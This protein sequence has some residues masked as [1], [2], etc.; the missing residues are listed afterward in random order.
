MFI[1]LSRVIIKFLE[2]LDYKCDNFTKTLSL[3]SANE[4]I[5]SHLHAI[6]KQLANNNMKFTHLVTYHQI[7]S[8]ILANSIKAEL[9]DV[10]NIFWHSKIQ[11]ISTSRCCFKKSKNEIYFARLL[12]RNCRWMFYQGKIL[13]RTLLLISEVIFGQR[14]IQMRCGLQDDSKCEH[15]RLVSYKLYSNFPL[16]SS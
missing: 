12:S 16:F 6:N 7:K 9:F 1:L 5:R 15:L 2:I 3:P 4:V 8:Q 11:A 10:E 13:D 14:S